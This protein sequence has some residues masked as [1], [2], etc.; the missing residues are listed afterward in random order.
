MISAQYMRF[1][2]G[3]HGAIDHI[4]GLPSHLP[5]AFPRVGNSAQEMAFLAQL[6]CSPSRLNLAGMLCVHLY[7]DP[8]VGEG[9][10]PLP[11]ALALPLGS[12]INQESLGTANPTISELD[13]VWEERMDPDFEPDMP[14]DLPLYASK[15]GGLCLHSYL[16]D[17]TDQFLFQLKEEPAGF[18]FAGRTCLVCLSSHG[19]LRVYLG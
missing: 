4:G 8:D 5:A 10:D 1:E 14:D 11:I 9:G 19:D 17:P 15:V 16:F 13:V 12:T 2:E 18:N 3:R 6:Y 7:Q